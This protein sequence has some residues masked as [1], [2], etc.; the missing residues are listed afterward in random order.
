[1]ATKKR[2]TKDRLVRA[3]MMAF[4]EKKTQYKDYVSM[5]LDSGN[6]S[7]RTKELIRA[8]VAYSRDR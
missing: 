4:E 6:H 8:C 5:I 2:N 7:R 3:I 1:M